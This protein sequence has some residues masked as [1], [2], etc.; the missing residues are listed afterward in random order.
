MGWADSATEWFD[1]AEDIRTVGVGIVNTAAANFNPALGL[2]DPTVFA[3]TLLSRTIESSRAAFVLAKQAFL[4]E[5]GM[6]TRSCIENVLWMRSLVRDGPTFANSIINDGARADASIAELIKGLG[7]GLTLAE[8]FDELD[9]VIAR[10]TKVRIELGKLPD[11]NDAKAEYVL[12]RMLSNEYGHVSRSSLLRHIL[13]DGAVGPEIDMR[14]AAKRYD[15]LWVMFLAAA[16]VLNAAHLFI[17]TFPESKRARFEESGDAQSLE[18][19]R[20]RLCQ[21]RD[22]NG[23]GQ[24]A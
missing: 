7:D 3:V 9:S 20:A 1:V 10:K 8:D 24:P 11:D 15:L 14:P 12:F 17:M 6:V 21:L 19:V 18:R 23:L 2:K 4:V 16:S 22:E 5:A 13:L